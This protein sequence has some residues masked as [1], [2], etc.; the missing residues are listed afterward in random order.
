MISQKA[1][2]WAR[3]QC[4]GSPLRKKVVLGVPEQESKQVRNVKERE[5]PP[6]NS[7]MGEG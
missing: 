6:E 3:M 7:V 2:S 4:S 5:G 1:G